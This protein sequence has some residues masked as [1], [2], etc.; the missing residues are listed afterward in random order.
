MNTRIKRSSKRSVVAIIAAALIASVLSLVSSP[1]S[2]AQAVTITTRATLQGADRYA[3][4]VA[5]HNVAQTANAGAD[6]TDLVL[7][8][9]DNYP[10]ALSGIALAASQDAGLILLPADGTMSAAAVLACTGA[11]Q[12]RRTWATT[13]TIQHLH[14]WQRT[15]CLFPIPPILN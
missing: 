13:T 10:D 12:P 4:S 11:T 9:G 8:S 7:A 2:A 1:A 14:Y 3:T 5:V 15:F 6:F